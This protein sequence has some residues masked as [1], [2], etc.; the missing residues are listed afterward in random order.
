MSYRDDQIRKRIKK[1]MHREGL[2][3]TQFA[4]KIGKSQPQVSDIMRGKVSIT[5]NFI[6]DIVRAFPSVNTEW[7]SEGDNLMYQGDIAESN[8]FALDTRPRLPKTF[9]ESN[10]EEFIKNH[11]SQCQE[12]KTITQ[13]AEYEFTLILKNDRMSPKYLR[14]DEL[15]FRKA[16]FV[17][18]GN[19]YLLDTD[20]GPKFKRVFEE[21]DEDGN[22]I[23]RCVS[24][25]KD[26]YPDFPIPMDKIYEF[27]KCVGVIRVL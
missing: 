22:K 15:A 23:V 6:D 7:L 24:Y 8:S 27:Y 19:D 17:E 11:R 1:L 9:M 4:E 14:G 25:N 21:V 3:Q 13:F 5:D 20:E 26:A 16:S 18:W 2:N 12:K 10:I